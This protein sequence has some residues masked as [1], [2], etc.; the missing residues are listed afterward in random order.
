MKNNCLV[1]G[2][3]E[4]LLIQCFGFVLQINIHDWHCAVPNMVLPQSLPLQLQ[5][6]AF[7]CFPASSCSS[8]SN[9]PLHWQAAF[10]QAAAAAAAII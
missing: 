10:Q 2:I 6:K 3:F 1:P 8:H 7:S 5:Q 4:G 9:C